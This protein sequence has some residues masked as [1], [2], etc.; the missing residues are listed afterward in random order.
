MVDRPSHPLRRP[1]PARAGI[2]LRPEHYD[3]VLAQPPDVAWLEVHSENYFG[4]G[5]RPLNV[6]AAVAERYPLSFHGIG[7]SLGSTD[8]VDRNHV[9]QLKH[10]IDRFRPAFVSDHLAWRSVDGAHFNDLLPLPYTLEALELVEQR[11]AAVQDLLGR[12]LLVEN[13]SS[14]LGFQASVIPEAEFLNELAERTGCGLLL[15][16]NNVYVSACNQGF[17]PADY[18]DSIVGDRVVEIH[19][20]GHTV[21]KIDGT[22]LLIDTHSA[23]VADNV[24]TLY[25]HL[26]GRIGPRPTLIEWD[27]DLPPLETLVAEARHANHV[28]EEAPRGQLA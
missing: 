14:Y 2:G 20:A 25:E 7:L 22:R 21:R 23:P 4:A 24:W 12:R 3:A 28:L 13:P 17:D 19:L 26:I 10:L 1:I 5:G 11:V 9:D 18:L 6:L 16:V 27:A 8:P 15:D